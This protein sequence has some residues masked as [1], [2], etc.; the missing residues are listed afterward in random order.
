MINNVQN[1]V[2]T[3]QV[4][5]VKLQAV[6]TTKVLPAEKSFVKIEVLENVKGNF[7]ILVDGNLF[8]SKLPVKAQ[9]GDVLFAQVLSRN[10]FTLTLDNFA[11]G[12]AGE[13]GLAAVIL[14][15]LGLRKTKLADKFISALLK[16]KKP[17]SRE[18]LKKAL[19]FMDK[20]E[21]DFDAVQFAFLSAYFWDDNAGSFSQKTSVY[22]R[23]FDLNFNQ[24]AEAIYRKI[25]WLSAQ[26]LETEFYETLKGKLIFETENF[27]RGNLYTGL[28][29]KVKS[30]IEFVDFLEAYERKSLLSSSLKRGIDEFKE[31]LIKY[32]LQKSLLN[33]YG[34]YADFAVTLADEG[35]HLWRFEFVKVISSNG[36]VVYR[37][38]TATQTRR[39]EKISAKVFITDSK[40]QGEVQS[41]RK[42]D[43]KN[44]LNRLNENLIAK[45]A[46]HSNIRPYGEE[47]LSM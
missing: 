3:A 5:E 22:R 20:T 43:W 35:L 14:S 7:K 29:G 33:K 28:F 42:A 18:K 26:N 41:E 11:I 12:K 36:D 38:E 9:A 21:I 16:S 6:K 37:L 10:P 40:V 39:G 2:R 34:V 31:L 32:V 4:G 1:I 30:A 44:A 19:E 27:E 46:V 15:K 13:S 23:V 8:Q 47:Y 17:L 24:L 45:L 25:V